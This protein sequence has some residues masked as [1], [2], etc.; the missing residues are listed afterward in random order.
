M[1]HSALGRDA[2]G[3]LHVALEASNAYGDDKNL[4]RV[5]RAVEALLHK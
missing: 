1:Y 5:I 2:L 4:L 3:A